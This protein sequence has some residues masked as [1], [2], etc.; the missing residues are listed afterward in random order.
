MNDV[1]VFFIN[2]YLL[3]CVGVFCLQICKGYYR[4]A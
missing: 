3:L 1:A 2:I 4:Y